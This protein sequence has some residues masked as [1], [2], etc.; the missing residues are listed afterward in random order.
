MAPGEEEV[1]ESIPVPDDT[2]AEANVDAVVRVAPVK[3]NRVVVIQGDH[4]MQK[5]LLLGED[6]G[7]GMVNL[8]AHGIKL[9]G[10]DCLSRL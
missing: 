1:L 3:G 8:D 10:L 5:G 2:A 4:I 6:D 7:D 9:I